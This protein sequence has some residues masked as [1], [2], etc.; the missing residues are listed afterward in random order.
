MF[1]I[2][3]KINYTNNETTFNYNV[4]FAPKISSNEKR[5]FF[6]RNLINLTEK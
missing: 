2:K 5:A 1:Q 3:N 6:I 4:E